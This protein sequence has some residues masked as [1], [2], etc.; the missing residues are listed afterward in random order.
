MRA[1]SHTLTSPHRAPIA[2]SGAVLRLPS[3]RWLVL[4]GG[5]SEERRDDVGGVS[6][7]G[8]AGSVIAHGGAWVGMTG[9][10]LDVA[11]WDAGMEGGGDDPVAQRVW[12]DSFGDPGSPGEATHDPSG[13]VTIQPERHGHHRSE[14]PGTIKHND[15]T[16]RPAEPL[17]S[18]QYVRHRHCS[19]L[20]FEPP[21]TRG[22]D[23]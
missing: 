12:S 18:G 13:G 7:E 17:P 2:R 3:G 23:L 10:F 22:G 11:Q 8:D 20:W 4:S 14:N 9:G 16:T 6:V 21:R 5:A 15:R 19:T 1:T